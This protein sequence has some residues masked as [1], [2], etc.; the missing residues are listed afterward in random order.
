VFSSIAR[1]FSRCTGEKIQSNESLRFPRGSNELQASAR[2]AAVGPIVV[3]AGHIV[4][5]AAVV[6]RS[7]INPTT[8][9]AR[10]A[11]RRPPAK[12]RAHWPFFEG[13]H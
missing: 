6:W 1:A 10:S 8:G 3:A 4:V 12:Q 7:V 5:A 11:Q 2:R 9:G 13:G